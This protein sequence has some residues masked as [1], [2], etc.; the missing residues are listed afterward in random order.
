LAPYACRWPGKTDPAVKLVAETGNTGA[1]DLV[2][3]AHAALR[4]TRG[5]ALAVAL[6]DTEK[7]ELSFCGVGNIAGCIAHGSTR[8][9]LMSHN[10]IVGSN[11]RKSQEFRHEW[12]TGA[13]LILH[14]DGIATRWDVDAYPGL[15]FRH[16][17]LIA[18]VLYRDFARP[19]DDSLVLVIRERERTA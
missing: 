10:G 17:A 18:A 6:I 2:T 4:G 8:R 12:K 1:C 15:S 14:S 11:L 19:R 5:A 16:P 7:G 13:L 3:L 9:H